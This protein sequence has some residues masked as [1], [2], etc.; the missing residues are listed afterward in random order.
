MPTKE[1]A[2]EVLPRPRAVAPPR[3]DH[4]PAPSVAK[5]PPANGLPSLARAGNF[6]GISATS[7]DVVARAQMSLGLQRSVGNARM[8]AL[9]A[10]SAERQPSE[11]KIL[12]PFAAPPAPLAPKPAHMT[13]PVAP[14][15]PLL[16]PT[17][18]RLQVALEHAQEPGRPVPP[19]P[20]IEP[21]A[22]AKAG[23]ASAHPVR[24]PGIP[25]VSE[26][27]GAKRT[28]GGAG[29]EDKSKMPEAA[30][31]AKRTEGGKSEVTAAEIGRAHV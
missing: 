9:L 24:E 1:L 13:P 17:Q 29:R 18:A 23:D 26:G 7:P 31:G 27:T 3:V 6:V 28:P 20:A 4:A 11:A 12:V 19:Q 2:H 5:L 10:P 22:V 8:E 14:G 25:T 21:H 16:P 30:A 15:S